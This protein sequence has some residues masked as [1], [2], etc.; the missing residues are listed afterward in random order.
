MIRLFILV[1][2]FFWSELT[3]LSQEWGVIPADN[4]TVANYED[5]KEVLQK[6][7]IKNNFVNVYADLCDLGF[8]HEEAFTVIAS[9]FSIDCS[10]LCKKVEKINQSQRS[11]YIVSNNEE[12][13]SKLTQQCKVC[14]L[15]VEKNEKKE[16]SIHVVVKPSNV[17]LATLLKLI[18]AN[19]QKYR[20]QISNKGVQVVSDERAVE[21]DKKQ[22]EL[23][24]LNFTIIAAI[25]EEYGYP[26][27]DIVG[28]D[29]QNVALFV[30]HHNPD[31]ENHEIYFPVMERA[32]QSNQISAI[33]FEMYQLR[34]FNMRS[35]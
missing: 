25:I 32:F 8:S 26:G 18:H 28:S 6:D 27:K 16:D 2:V 19:D 9:F 22:A 14:S 20:Q 23:D 5:Y 11:Y 13:W 34:L 29:L 31:I 33:A 1:L 4:G 15:N 10:L 12:R 21:L 17:E 35:K 24:Q 7:Y 30:I 3:L